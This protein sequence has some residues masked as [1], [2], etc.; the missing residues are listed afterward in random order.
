MAFD[1]EAEVLA[2]LRAAQPYEAVKAAAR[3]A[4]REERW[5]RAAV[6]AAL[7][8]LRAGRTEADEDLLLDVMDGVSGWCS[9]DQDLGP[10][11]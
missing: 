2:G 10:P 7:E 4:L 5:T 6:L 1:L 8:R 3:R 11:G 9:P